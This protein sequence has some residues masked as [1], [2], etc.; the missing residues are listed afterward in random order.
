MFSC[1]AAGWAGARGRASGAAPPLMDR[2]LRAMTALFAA[3]SGVIEVYTTSGF[4]PLEAGVD[5]RLSWAPSLDP[6]SR[7]TSLRIQVWQEVLRAHLPGA[8]AGAGGCLLLRSCQLPLQAAQA[9]CQAQCQCPQP[10]GC[11]RARHLGEVKVQ[12]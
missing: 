2:L 4:L 11:L 3:L 6:R 5:E 12:R 1:W 9:L 10:G 7:A 8:L